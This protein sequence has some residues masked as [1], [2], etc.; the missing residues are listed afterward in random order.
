MTNQ[1]ETQAPNSPELELNDLDAV[2]GGSQLG[3]SMGFAP[4][5]APQDIIVVC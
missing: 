5:P 3:S 1:V 4:T 2:I